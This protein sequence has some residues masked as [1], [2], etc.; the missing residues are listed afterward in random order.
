MT[1]HPTNPTSH[2]YTQASISLV[3]SIINESDSIGDYIAQLVKSDS[4]SLDKETQINE[5][6]EGLT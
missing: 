6:E 2:Q 5:V 3:D 4:Y 1:A